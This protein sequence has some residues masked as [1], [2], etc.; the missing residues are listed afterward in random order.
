MR[1]AGTDD[2]RGAI[3]DALT[4]DHIAANAVL[5]LAGGTFGQRSPAIGR[6]TCMLPLTVYIRRS[7]GQFGSRPSRKLRNGMS[8]VPLEYRRTT[9]ARVLLAARSPSIE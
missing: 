1:R 9:L 3:R 2:H 8:E 4:V 5:V 7:S 6:S